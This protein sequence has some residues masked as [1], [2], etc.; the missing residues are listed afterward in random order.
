MMPRCCMRFKVKYLLLSA[1]LIFLLDFFGVFI[2][3]FEL[4]YYRLF[5]YPLNGDVL[6]Y[7]HQLRFH[8]EPDVQ[9]IN[10]YN[11]TFSK[12]CASK[13][14]E[15]GA[16]VSPQLVFLVKS[17]M[18]NFNRRSAIRKSWGYERRFSDVT[19]RTVFLL[20]ISDN[21]E[22]Q[23]HIDIES[24][25]YSDIVQANFVDTYF[26]NTIKTM[27]G[28]QW[29][30]RFCPRS[31][32]YM[33]VDD[34]FYI[35]AKNVLRF[36]RNPAK[37]PD[38]LA[39]ADETLRKLARK[40]NQSDFRNGTP[41]AQ[42]LKEA[43]Q[44]VIQGASSFDN[45]RHFHRI[46]EFV[47]KHN[48]PRTFNNGSRVKRHIMDME[49][50]SDA[51]LFAGFVFVSSPHRH[52]SS[53][54]HVTLSEY[55]FHLWPPYVTA[56][57]F[58]VSREALFEM[59]FTSMFTKHF[60]F[61]DIYLGIVALKARIEPL[62]C[63]EFYFHKAPYTGPQSYRYVVASHGYDNSEELIKVWTEARAAGHA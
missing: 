36:V 50:P 11:Y 23:K 57:A 48:R 29:A 16:P 52:R 47:N 12:E 24:D 8:Q 22:L 21:R 30:V 15:E 10:I 31:R 51:K 5:S 3:M 13:C 32:F 1:V 59:Y 34:D 6:H 44:V 61:D 39:E 54:W 25:Q 41:N 60:R 40:L 49:L 17:A 19:I 53:K 43:H 38:Y 58:I 18:K 56:G 28:F 20:G 14:I 62:H 7:A 63:K 35:S 55:P 9:P 27:M 33:F 26:N 4:D 46:E 2:H 37:Y 42:F 45:K